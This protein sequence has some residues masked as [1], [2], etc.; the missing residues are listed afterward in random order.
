ML[1][2]ELLLPALACMIHLRRMSRG[3]WR[4]RKYSGWL[5]CIVDNYGRRKSCRQGAVC[6]KFDLTV[7]CHFCCVTI[8]QGTGTWPG[9]AAD[10]MLKVFQPITKWEDGMELQCAVPIVLNIIYDYELKLLICG[11]IMARTD[12]IYILLSPADANELAIAVANELKSVVVNKNSWRTKLSHIF[13]WI[14]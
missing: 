4:C 6:E 13:D 5:I 2:E 14:L 7:N 3:L 11:F 9:K 12:W 1:Y 8:M 10:W